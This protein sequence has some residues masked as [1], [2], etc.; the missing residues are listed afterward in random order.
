[1]LLTCSVA[2]S[3]SLS[4]ILPLYSCWIFYKN[5]S[6]HHCSKSFILKKDSFSNAKNS[7]KA[8]VHTPLVWAVVN[9]LRLHHIFFCKKRILFWSLQEFCTHPHEKF[10]IFIFTYDSW[11]IPMPKKLATSPAFHGRWIGHADGSYRPSKKHFAKRFFHLG[12]IKPTIRK[13]YRWV[14][15]FQI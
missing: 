15:N 8:L 1:M 12:Q 7:L 4:S 2:L 9:L 3:V 13:F 6:P 14:L 11:L 10:H 5:A